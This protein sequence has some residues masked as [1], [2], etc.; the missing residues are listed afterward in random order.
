M[1]NVARNL[2][3]V[4]EMKMNAWKNMFQIS[5]T[6]S[7]QFRILFYLLLS[8]RHPSIQKLETL[9]LIS[10]KKYKWYVDVLWHSYLHAVFFRVYYCSGS[11]IQSLKLS[12]TATI[13][14]RVWLDSSSWPLESYWPSCWP[15]SFIRSS[16]LKGVLWRGTSTSASPK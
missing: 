1:R 11:N 13:L 12:I 6:N 10:F 7:S 4:F 14:N 15:L 8:K 3:S 9:A 5:G 2:N 16:P